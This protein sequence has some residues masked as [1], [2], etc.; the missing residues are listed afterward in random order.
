MHD[1]HW[2]PVWVRCIRDQHSHTNMYMSSHTTCPSLA[3]STF[4]SSWTAFRQQGL[5][6]LHLLNFLN[7]NILFMF[8]DYSS[9]E[10]RDK[11]CSI[12]TSFAYFTC[13]FFIRK[14]NLYRLTSW[15]A[16]IAS[17]SQLTL[18]YN[19]PFDYSCE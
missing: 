9:H 18:H 13:E 10:T 8:Y 15:S 4:F 3:T 1:W 7:Q 6:K 16:S 5:F 19:F 11:G 12:H 14:Y 17:Y 2:L